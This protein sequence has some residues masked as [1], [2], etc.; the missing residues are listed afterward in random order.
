MPLECGEFDSSLNL[1]ISDLLEL[2]L[3]NW[4]KEYIQQEIRNRTE[5]NRCCW[6]RERQVS[7]EIVQGKL[8][9]GDKKIKKKRIDERVE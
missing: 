4:S 6:V 3:K 2:P 9:S 1:V 8:E 5:Q 7:L